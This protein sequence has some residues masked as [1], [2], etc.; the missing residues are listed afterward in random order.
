MHKIALASFLVLLVIA[1]L[2]LSPLVAETTEKDTAGR[3][4]VPVG[5]AAGPP[6]AKKPEDERLPQG[7]DY[8]EGGSAV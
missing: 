5:W 3:P 6:P 2:P 8:I 7:E 4:V 1:A